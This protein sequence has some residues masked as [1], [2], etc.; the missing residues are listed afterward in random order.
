MLPSSSAHSPSTLNS[1]IFA[2]TAG[3]SLTISR[4]SSLLLASKKSAPAFPE[5]CPRPDLNRD[6]RFRKPL[7]F[8][9]SHA[10]M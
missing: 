8:V 5:W 6:K 3:S 7:T 10:F 2:F 4:T 1:I 9:T